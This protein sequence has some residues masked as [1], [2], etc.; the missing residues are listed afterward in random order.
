MRSL[1]IPALAL[2]A[3]A[4][5]GATPEA[6]VA[7]IEPPERIDA[8]PSY[9]ESEIGGMNQYDVEDTFTRLQD[10]IFSCVRDGTDRLRE[11]GGK[12]SVKLRV[13]KKGSVI[14]AY[15]AQSTL[16]DR[17]TERCVLEVARSVSW[18]KPLGGEGIAE[19]SFDVD[20]SVEPVQWKAEKV[21]SA[22]KSLGQKLDKCYREVIGSARVPEE[23]AFT[24]TAYIDARGKVVA[25]G[26]APPHA[27]GERAADCLVDALRA[28]KFGSPGRKAAK[29]TFEI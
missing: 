20:P 9:M 13:N 24:A 29:V 12:F 4:C 2:L 5:G 25:A 15:L 26:V 28:T 22:R 16:G 27:A 17:E 1:V 14:S 7:P 6:V 10:P 18:P 8:G 3:L 21:R 19:R 23:G 11:M